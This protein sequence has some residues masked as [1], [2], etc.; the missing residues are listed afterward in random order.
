WHGLGFDRILIIE[1]RIF[2]VLYVI[3]LRCQANLGLNSGSKI[4]TRQSDLKSYVSTAIIIIESSGS[5][6]RY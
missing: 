1:L 4:P 3:V 6:D 2:G 5:S